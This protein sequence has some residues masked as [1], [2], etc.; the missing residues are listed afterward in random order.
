MLIEVKDLSYSLEHNPVL[1]NLSLKLPSGKITAILGANGS[2]KSTLLRLISGFLDPEAGEIIFQNKK[3]LGP[4]FRLLPGH[5]GI[6]LVRQDNRLFPL[7]TVRQN[8]RRVLQFEHKETQENKIEEL[9]VLLNLKDNL[10]KVLKH[11]SG[12]EQQRVSIA[13]A[14]ASEPQLLLMDEPFSQTDMFLKQQL[15]QYL[16]EIVE[17]LGTSIL[18]VTHNPDDALGLANEIMILDEG[19]ILE[20]GSS[21]DLYYFPKF[22]STAILTGYCNWLPVDLF[23][24][25]QNLQVIEGKYLVRPEQITISLMETK[26]A[27]EATL[28]KEEFCG[29]FQ[30]QHLILKESK[31]PLIVT[32]LS[33]SPP[34]K[35]GE[36]VWIT[37]R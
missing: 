2:G 34:V 15:K 5:A 13:A 30:L 22:K 3:V 8:L 33:S 1:K 10:N 7:H 14:L 17:H 6:S 26:F 27:L 20:H 9:S 24:K 36:K 35:S 16:I 25:R 21:K 18:F 29:F 31:I 32:K 11:L 4:S 12:G 37:V 28:V 23:E 19:K